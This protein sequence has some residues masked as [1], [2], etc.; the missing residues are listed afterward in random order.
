VDG[1]S[2]YVDPG[3]TLGIV[4]ESG[5]G[6]SLTALSIM[7]L[8]PPGGQIQSGTVRLAGRDITKLEENEMRRI[9]G[10][11]VSIIFQ[12]PLSSLNPTMTIGRQVGE[13]LKAHRRLSDV[14]VHE[15]CLDMLR[16]VGI[17]QPSERMGEYP[18][19]LSGGLR[20][21]VMIAMALINE[22]KLL[23]ADEPTT[24]LDVTI[25]Q[26]IL[27]LLRELQQKLKMA[28][29]LI[30]HDLGVIAGRADRVAVMYAGKIVEE[31]D[32]SLIFRATRHR[33]TEALL[34]TIPRVDRSEGGQLY[35]IPGVPPDLGEPQVACRF[36]ERCRFDSDLC[37]SVEPSLTA[38]VNA[39]RFACHHPAGLVPS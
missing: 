16:L 6:K 34:E 13:A 15:R 39:H 10:S 22:P 27:D 11:D 37:H 28:V 32:V 19:T 3:E 2:A 25:Q 31:G 30:T 35:S 1:V 36:A 33:Y 21:R 18:H 7:R 8:L 12:D 5:C 23:I 17:P 9:R 4:G 26:Q 14:E 20:Q 29:I 38:D 24:A